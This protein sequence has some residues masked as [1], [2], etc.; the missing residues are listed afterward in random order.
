MRTEIGT[1]MFMAFLIASLLLSPADMLSQL[2]SGI[3]TMRWRV[4]SVRRR[5]MVVA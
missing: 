2:T 1:G 5:P 4:S 3:A